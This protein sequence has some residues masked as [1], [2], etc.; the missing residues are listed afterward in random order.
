M[1]GA[2][3]ETKEASAPGEVTRTAGKKPSVAPDD[4]GQVSAVRASVDEEAR[5]AGDEEAEEARVACEL[6]EH[7]ALAAVFDDVRAQSADSALV[8]PTRWAARG[9]VPEHMLPEDFEMFVYEYLE[10]A[11]SMRADQTTVEPPAYRSATR[12]VGVP[13]LKTHDEKGMGEGAASWIEAGEDAPD[14]APDEDA[15]DEAPDED[16]PDGVSNG[17]PDEDALDEAPDEDAPGEAFDE[18]FDKDVSDGVPDEGASPE[19]VV[20]SEAHGI[21]GEHA[22]D[23]SATDDPFANLRIPDGFKLVELEGEFVL[24][25]DEHAAPVERTIECANVVALVGAQSYYLYDR[26]VMTDA[27]AH[28]AFLAAEDNHVV[29]FVDCVREDSRVYPR[30]LAASSLTNEPFAFRAEDV[31]R[32]WDIVRESGEYPDIGQTIASNGDVYY[33][34]TDYL[35][36]RY[37]AS[38]AEWDAVERRMNM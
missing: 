31:A 14:E 36:E 15:P 34:S 35:S 8:Q 37:A 1:T 26:S 30:P 28:W 4:D 33:F 17:V 5:V 19:N 16:A 23:L 6:A 10:E 7:N 2:R 20:D 9:M 21:G 12:A 22:A 24:A 29:T 32:T 25:P 3:D 11:Q 18:A 13:C 38:L 27:Y